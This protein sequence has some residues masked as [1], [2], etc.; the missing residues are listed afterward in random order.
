M[1]LATPGFYIFA[2]PLLANTLLLTNHLP[3]SNAHSGQDAAGPTLPI[4][5]A[6]QRALLRPL[7]GGAGMGG[8]GE[9]WV[10]FV[11]DGNPRL[12]LVTLPPGS[13][14]ASHWA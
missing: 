7:P 8:S 1:A 2:F 12:S 13:F 10:S 11:E 4:R 14:P 3:S 6:V 5:L 9:L